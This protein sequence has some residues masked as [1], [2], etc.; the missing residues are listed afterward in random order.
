MFESLFGTESSLR[1]EF[2]EPSDEID[3][4]LGDSWVVC[5]N[6]LFQLALVPIN[7]SK[8]SPMF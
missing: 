7:W 4:T 5:F 1:I 8:L 6:N 3:S 2:Q